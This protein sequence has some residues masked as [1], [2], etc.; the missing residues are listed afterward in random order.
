MYSDRSK[1]DTRAAFLDITKSHLAEL[2]FICMK[3][4]DGDFGIVKK[5]E[6]IDGHIA[7]NSRTTTIRYVYHTVDEMLDAGWVV[8]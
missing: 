4:Y 3:Q 1:A 5:E 2:P 8:D 7:I 6:L